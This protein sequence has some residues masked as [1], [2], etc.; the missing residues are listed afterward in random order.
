MTLPG[1]E[2]FCRA[3]SQVVGAADALGL[4]ALPQA[5]YVRAVAVA[6]APPVRN[7]L[8]EITRDS[9][10]VGATDGAIVRG[11][12]AEGCPRCAPLW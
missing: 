12:K 2:R 8:R 7:S 9:R 10:S 4:R 3:S 6:A 1:N 11:V 5:G